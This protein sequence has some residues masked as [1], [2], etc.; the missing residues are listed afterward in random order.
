MKQRSQATGSVEAFSST[1]A[2]AAGR[3]NQTTGNRPSQLEDHDVTNSRTPERYPRYWGTVLLP[4]RWRHTQLHRGK[5]K[6]RARQRPYDHL[7][8]EAAHGAVTNFTQAVTKP[9]HWS[10]DRPP[11]GSNQ[12]L[13]RI[14]QNRSHPGRCFAR[15][16][17]IPAVL[18]YIQ[19]FCSSHTLSV[20]RWLSTKRSFDGAV[21]D[22]GH[23][24]APTVQRV[25]SLGCNLS[26][27][28]GFCAWHPTR[29]YACET[30]DGAEPI[31]SSLAT[32][33]VS[34]PVLPQAARGRR[35]AQPKL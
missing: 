15:C 9:A 26:S 13:G 14:P 35:V 25:S 23:V 32:V 19:K 21:D 3:Y 10:W 5:N 8:R 11:V 2:P 27:R 18:F 34:Q 12:N 6:T 24:P 30:A 29:N 31:P 7:R 1:Q 22:D 16:T 28:E 17:I 4:H 20:G 33:E